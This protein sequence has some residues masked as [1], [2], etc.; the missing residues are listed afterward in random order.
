MPKGTEKTEIRYQQQH[1]FF[2]PHMGNRQ[3]L[4]NRC[5]TFILRLIAPA[6]IWL[7]LYLE[8]LGPLIFETAAATSYSISRAAIWTLGHCT[9]NQARDTRE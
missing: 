1:L 3:K 4:E 6:T 2:R 5:Y 8:L 9:D 7:L